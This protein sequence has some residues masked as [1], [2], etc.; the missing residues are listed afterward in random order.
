MLS[1]YKFL[2]RCIIAVINNTNIKEYK[3]L[4]VITYSIVVIVKKERSDK[5]CLI[6]C[7]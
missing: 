1:K 4:I 3:S 7:L 5:K 2:K 6:S